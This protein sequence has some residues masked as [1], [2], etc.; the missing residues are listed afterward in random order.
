MKLVLEN[1]GEASLEALVPPVAV[2]VAGTE[3]KLGYGKNP[4]PCQ[5]YERVGGC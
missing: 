3:R 4:G 1:C 5:L 2:M